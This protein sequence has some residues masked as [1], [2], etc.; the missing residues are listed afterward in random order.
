[1][2]LL[3]TAAR[4]FA[5]QLCIAASFALVFVP[6][7]QA[8]HQSKATGS[9]D[10][11]Q[12]RDIEG[13]VRDY[14]L[15]HPE[16]I[17]DAINKL[18]EQQQQAEELKRQEAA[19]AVKPVVAEDHTL[20]N[21]SAPVKLIEFADFECP[22]CKRFH[23]TIKQVIEEYGKTGKV[24]VTY[25]HFPL[26]ELHSKARKE[27]QAAECANEIGGN[28]AFWAYAD[29]IFEITPSND[30]LDLALLPRI[31]E[32]IGLDR[33]K[34]EACLAG[35]MRGGKYATHIEANYQDAIA[36]GGSGTPYT[37]VISAKGQIFSINGA[38]PYEAVKSIIE[39]ALKDK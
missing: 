15:S 28:N 10:A 26:D 39:V 29:R 18:N 3:A 14:I 12:S 13:I 27:A 7:V 31:A 19:K 23:P 11:Q 22:F 30:R 5:M 34:F 37:L 33:S 32:E 25:R 4:N 20:G 35:D 24:A 17:A 21:P 38:Q 36:S 16:V 8:T 9:F 2:T 1:M 6:P